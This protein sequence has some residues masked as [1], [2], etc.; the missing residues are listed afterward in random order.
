MV[1]LVGETFRLWCVWYEKIFKYINY[2]FVLGLIAN[3]NYLVMNNYTK[4]VNN[5]QKNNQPYFNFTQTKYKI[6]I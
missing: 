1:C 3:C 5:K 6:K 2:V 4:S